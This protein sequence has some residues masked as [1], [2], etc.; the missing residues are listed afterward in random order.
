[1]PVLLIIGAIIF[2]IGVYH[3][4][5]SYPTANEGI[6]ERPQQSVPEPAS[7]ALLASGVAVVLARRRRK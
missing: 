7:I 4:A 3:D 1:M 5:H 2:G 6:V